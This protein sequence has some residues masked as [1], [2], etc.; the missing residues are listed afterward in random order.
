M[1]A[2][3][4]II[5]PS[6]NN[7]VHLTRLLRSIKLNLERHSYLKNLYEVIVV[8]DGSK[9]NLYNLKNLFK[10]KYI[11]KKNGGAASARN[12]GAKYAKGKFLF[13]LDSDLE[14]TNNFLNKVIYILK[15]KK[16]SVLS[17]YYNINSVNKN[18]L[19]ASKLKAV[20][21][22]YINHKNQCFHKDQLIH[23]QCVIISKN[24][25]ERTFGWDESIEKS[26]CEHEEYSKRILEKS[27]IFTNFKIGPFHYYKNY[28]I[29][30]KEVFERS[31]IWSELFYKNKVNK[32]R[33]F[34]FKKIFFRFFPIMSLFSILIDYKIFLLLI[35]IFYLYH[36][37]LYRMLINLKNFN[38]FFAGI[39]FYP[40]IFSVAITGSISGTLL[41]IYKNILDYK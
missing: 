26:I 34:E 24:F 15:S 32:D 20:L 37:K 35:A 31:K 1:R 21:D 13:F 19:L 36:F 25:F 6:Y 14:L 39:L 28:L 30:I 22:I 33:R 16:I 40:I 9:E 23:G 3:I 18:L 27:K 5:I 2:F 41:S 10:F 7:K 38:L 4:S 8:D 29:T 17:F 11:K 12:F